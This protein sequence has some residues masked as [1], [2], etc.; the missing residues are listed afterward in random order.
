L[1]ITG[2]EAPRA[3][4]CSLGLR[5]LGVVEVPPHSVY[6]CCLVAV[7]FAKPDGREMLPFEFTVLGP[8]VSHQSRNKARLDAWRKLVRSEAVKRWPLHSAL[9]E[10]LR[11]AVTYYHEGMAVR[12]DND[13]LIKPIQDALIGLIYVDDRLIT[14]TLIRKTSIDGLFRVR[15]ESMVFFEAM[16]KGDEFLHIIVDRAPAHEKLVK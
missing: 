16:S 3:N 10:N 11:I 8:P 6:N 7:V 1:T 2:R 4:R 15:W 5:E 12:I 14:E 9:S 13:N